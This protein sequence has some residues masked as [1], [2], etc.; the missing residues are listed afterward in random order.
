MAHYGNTGVPRKLVQPGH[1]DEKLKRFCVW[2]RLGPDSM[3]QLALM[4]LS[5]GY[6]VCDD[7]LQLFWPSEHWHG[8]EPHGHW[9]IEDFSQQPQARIDAVLSEIADHIAKH[10]A[11]R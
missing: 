3:A 6:N 2:R 7:R 10:H 11:K 8:H 5:W 1:W 4:D 9:A